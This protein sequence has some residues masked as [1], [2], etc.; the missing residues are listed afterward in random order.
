MKILHTS[1]WHIGRGLFDYSLLEDQRHF[2]DE[3][4]ALA[5][6]ER[7]DA[8]IIAGDLYNRSV[9]SPAAVELLDYALC[10][11]VQKNSIPVLAVAGNH[12][13]PERLEFGAR[14][15]CGAGLHIAGTPRL[16]L[17]RVKISSGACA[18][19]VWLLPYF[20]PSD[21]RGMFP[22]RKISSF[23]DAFLALIEENAQFLDESETNI[24]VAHGF[25]AALGGLESESA[26]FSAS[27]LSIGTMDVMDISAARNFDYVALGHL[28]APQRVSR[29]SARYSGSP[30]KYSL[31]EERQKKS[32]TLLEIHGK[33]KIDVSQRSIPSL[34]DVRTVSGDFEKLCEIAAQREKS[35]D[36][37][38][39]ADITSSGAVLYAMDKLR[40]VFPNI[41]GLRFA[42]A[43]SGEGEAALPPGGG[44]RPMDE[45]FSQFYESVSGEALSEA[46]RAVVQTIQD[47]KEE[48]R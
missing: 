4:T 29:E 27:E 30:L 34:R 31:S 36:D 12:D 41:L 2:I 35:L 46:R 26:V 24:L 5:V 32:V 14:L 17:E 47:S 38:V 15:L 6:A 28:H 48:K 25:F 7:V 10:G 3:F 11:L 37:Y 21:V 43:I 8:V 44:L 9:P 23:N 33:G 19:T 20:T 13:S 16:P 39:F 18:V 42:A 1:D 22:E 45:M 40:R